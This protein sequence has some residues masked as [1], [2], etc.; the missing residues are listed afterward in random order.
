MR[1]GNGGNL[2]LLGN[3]CNYGNRYY[4]CGDKRNP[5][6]MAL[7]PACEAGPFLGE[8]FAEGFSD[9]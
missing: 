5:W 2:S 7:E 1:R 9:R 3:T 6:L 8:C 4:S